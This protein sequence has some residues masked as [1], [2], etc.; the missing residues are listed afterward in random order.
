MYRDVV[1]RKS[2]WLYVPNGFSAGRELANARP[3]I[4]RPYI[5]ITTMHKIPNTEKPR[6]S[7]TNNRSY[8]SRLTSDRRQV[9]FSDAPNPNFEK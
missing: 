3:L 1:I 6:I 9:K 8:L 7:I 2:A 4:T 5:G